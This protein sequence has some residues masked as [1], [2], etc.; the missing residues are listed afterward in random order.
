MPR[1]PAVVAEG[2]SKLY[3]IGEYKAGYETLRDTAADAARRLRRRERRN[4]S[5]TELWA[6]DDVS[7]EVKAGEVVGFI[8]HNGAGK[9]TLLKVLTRITPPTRGRATI[10]GRVG[11]ILEVGT[12]FHPELTGRENVLLNGAVLGMS[13]REVLSKFDEIVEF[14]GIGQFIDTPVKRYSSGM[15]VRL[16][17]AVAAHL[18]PEVLII[19]EVLAVGDHEFQQRCMGRIEDISGSGRT[20]LFVS[21]DMQAVSRLCD[22]AYWL[23]KGRVML[24]GPSESVV[25]Q[26]LQGRSGSGAER[27]WPL[28]EAPG[29]VRG[30]ITRARVVDVDSHTRN[31]VDVRERVGI[32]IDWF[33]EQV[34]EV[35]IFPK[36]KLTNQRGEVIFNALDTD[37][38]WHGIASPGQY[39]STAW[40]PSHLLNEG[41]VS[42]DVAIVTLG[43]PKLANVVNLPAVISFHVQDVGDDGASSKGRYTGQVKGV[44]RPLLEWTTVAD[45]PSTTPVA[46]A[47]VVVPRSA[48]DTA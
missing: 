15:Y 42:V 46:A 10:H 40:I 13:R 47:A 32:E 3:R 43:M 48:Y 31:A 26:Y 8:G 37:D 35:P 4:T 16:A 24:E 30:R 18:E 34:S 44:V 29:S 1:H 21:H 14:S 22:R 39:L 23:E 41:F 36:I 27:S 33:V 12:G 20:V 9:S 2:I 17:F 45:A 25:A 6:L 11:S 19:D 7:F 38:R 5:A 28:E